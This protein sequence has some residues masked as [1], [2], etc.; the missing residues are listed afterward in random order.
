MCSSTSCR[1]LSSVRPR[2]FATRGTWNSAPAGVM[3][4]SS[5]LAEVVTR[6]AGIGAFGFSAASFAA[7]SFTRSTSVFEVGP[8]LEP[9]E[10]AALYGA[11]TVLVA[12]FGSASVVADGR[13]G[14]TCRR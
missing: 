4:G 5:P 1:T 6:S 8:R 9:A 3:S 12:S 14:S 10:F 13:R 2:A 11:G 7:S